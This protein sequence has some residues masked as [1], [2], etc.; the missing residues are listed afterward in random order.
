MGWERM[1][2]DIGYGREGKGRETDRKGIGI[3]CFRTIDVV[4]CLMGCQVKGVEDNAM[5]KLHRVCL[6]VLEIYA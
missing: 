3:L 1:D 6:C 4:F 2:D 5:F